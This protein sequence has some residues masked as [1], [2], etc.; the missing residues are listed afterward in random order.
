MKKPRHLSAEEKALWEVVAKRADPLVKPSSALARPAPR[1]PIPLTPA[2][3]R[4]LPVFKVG[5][6]VNHSRDHDLL[7]SLGQQLKSAPVQMDQKAFGRLRRGKLKPEARID[8]HGMTMAQAHPAL[9]GFILRA[10]S[11]EHRLVLV[12]T[13]KGKDRDDDSPIPTRHGV[14]RHQVPQ[15]LSMAPLKGFV[16]QVSTAHVRHGGGGAYYVYLRRSR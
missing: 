14:L 13:G 15:W 16:L 8:L 10:A 4:M 11:A 9:T 2:A 5:Q 3:P 7:P 12:I 6:A 1:K